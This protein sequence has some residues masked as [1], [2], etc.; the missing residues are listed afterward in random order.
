MLLIE[1]KEMQM[2]RRPYTKNY[3]EDFHQTTHNVWNYI[4]PIAVHPHQIHPSDKCL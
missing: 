2:Q 1:I 3:Q 4:P